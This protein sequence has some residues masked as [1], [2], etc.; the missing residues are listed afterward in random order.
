MVKCPKCNKEN[1]CL[2]VASG[3]CYWCGYEAV[4][5]DINGY[6]IWESKTNKS[7]ESNLN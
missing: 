4:N 7:I 5:K 1:Y 2:M 6:S 3:I